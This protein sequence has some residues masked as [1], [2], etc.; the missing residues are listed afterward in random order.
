MTH[1]SILLDLFLHSK[2]TRGSYVFP[3]VCNKCNTWGPYFFS[4]V[5]I[6][7][8]SWGSYPSHQSRL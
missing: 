4:S 2:E 6:K 5:Y 3:R 1:S 8:K 7:C